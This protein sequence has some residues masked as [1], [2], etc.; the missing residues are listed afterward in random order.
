MKRSTWCP[1]ITGR[2]CR[3]RLFGLA[4]NSVIDWQ[5]C[6]HVWGRGGQ[7]RGGCDGQLCGQVGHGGVN[8]AGKH[9]HVDGITH[10]NQ[11]SSFTAV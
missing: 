5:S 7:A 3:E 11:I 6:C 2:A 9:A 4:N 8:Q 1:M 10:D